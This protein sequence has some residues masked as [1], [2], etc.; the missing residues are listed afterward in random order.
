VCPFAAVAVIVGLDLLTADGSMAAQV[1][2]FFPAL[3]GASQ[4]R[5]AGA[6]A[7]GAATVAGEVAVVAVEMPLREALIDAAYVGSALVATVV[8]LVNAGRRQDTLVDQL[9]RQAAIDPLTGL[10]TRRVLDHA[11]QSA[12]STAANGNGS[13]LIVLDV[14]NF[15]T[16]NDRY[17]H[18]AGDEVL[19]QLA[20]L[21]VSGCRGNDLVSRLGGD[22]IAMLLP[23]CSPDA[24]ARRADQILWDVRA[25]AF[26]IECGEALSISVSAGVAHAPTHAGDLRALYAAADSALYEAKRAGRNRVGRPAEVP[27]AVGR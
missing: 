15:K 9:K 16:I 24:L 3:Y 25:H 2:L 17:G 21:L 23:G 12:L 14:D 19:V 13:G 4:L 26:D 8:L 1:F 20:A 22:E 18:P 6:F 5:R 27:V 7:V 11:A 10:A